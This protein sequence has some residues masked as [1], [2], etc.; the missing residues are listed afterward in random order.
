MKNRLRAL[1]ER[2]GI[3]QADL[4]RRLGVTRQALSA[5]EIE[6]QAPSL[7]VA[8]R[9]GREL[10]TPVE[11]IFFLADEDMEA[12]KTPTLSKMERLNFANQ[13]AILKALHKDD[14]HSAEHYGYLQEIFLRGYEHLYYECFDNLWP[15]LS[16]DVAE[17]TLEILDMHRA[18]LWSLGEKP[19]PADVERVKF[20]GF[21]GN[22]EAEY[23]AFG[24]FYTADGTRYAELKV[25]NSHHPTLAR[26]RRMLAEW[27]SMGKEQQLSKAQIGTILEVSE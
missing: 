9:I 14:R 26:Y 4:A 16:E 25:V 19:D 22:N 24:R 2:E 15:A 27:E 1:R 13:F 21:D 11:Q 10:Y 20:R 7:P 12:T 6:K 5:V 18:I 8:I 3:S 17:E 23:L